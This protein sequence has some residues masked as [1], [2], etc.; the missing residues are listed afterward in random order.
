MENSQ[1]GYMAFLLRL[2]RVDTECG[3]VW[4]ASLEDPRSGR[5][6]GFVDLDAL[7]F[8]LSEQ[9]DSAL[10]ESA[11]PLPKRRLLI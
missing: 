9:C 11:V 6:Q 10:R 7:H 8:Y 2:W 5:R 3:C 4:R 1:V